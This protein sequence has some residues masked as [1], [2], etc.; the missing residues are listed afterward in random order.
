MR[1]RNLVD[2]WE[3]KKRMS[4]GKTRDRRGD[5]LGGK[6]W[7]RR[8]RE[9]E[10]DWVKKISGEFG[11]EEVGKRE[12]EAR[13]ERDDWV[14]GVLGGVGLREERED[15]RMKDKRGVGRNCGREKRM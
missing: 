3:W 14:R 15:W 4:W 12:E 11:S 6:W 7:G 10:E 5:W 2:Q 8:T 1:T 13:R 9:E